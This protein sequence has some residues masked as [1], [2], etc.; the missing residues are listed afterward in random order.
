M[1]NYNGNTYK[2][3]LVL[4]CEDSAEGILSA[5]YEAYSRRLNHNTTYIGTEEENYRL[6][7]RY[8]QVK[9]DPAK[10]QVVLK[11]LRREFREKD[12]QQLDYALASEDKEK[13]Q[14]IYRTIVAGRYQRYQRGYPCGL[15]D[16]LKNPYIHKTFTLARN[17][18]NELHHL[19]GF[20]RF[21]EMES[22]ILFARMG[23]K[24]NVLPF[25]SI[26]FTDRYPMENFVIY[27]EPRRL[28]SVHPAG[29]EWYLLQE[30][31]SEEIQ[32]QLKKSEREQ[33][34]QE[35][36]RYFCHKIAIKERKNEELQKGMLPLRFR[37]YMTEFGKK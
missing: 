26:H 24:N 21:E 17:T 9:T 35:L 34:Y 32:G 16:D 25:L 8:E 2:E 3:E 1:D 22:G 7:A 23:P 6:F 29:K 10:V 31:T 12:I 15:F 4:L 19:Q 11:T 13:G 30:N 18:W 20:L 14:S 27:D 5:V 33:D 28:F 36:F 37:N